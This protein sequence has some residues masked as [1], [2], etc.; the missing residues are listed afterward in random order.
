M[1][2]QQSQSFAPGTIWT[3]YGPE[4]SMYI[5]KPFHTTPKLKRCNE[6]IIFV[7]VFAR[8]LYSLAKIGEDLYLEAQKDGLALRSSSSSRSAFL[9]Y[10]VRNVFK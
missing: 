9:C 8:A 4:Q 5:I 2:L 7:P 6:P 1:H 10:L 3:R